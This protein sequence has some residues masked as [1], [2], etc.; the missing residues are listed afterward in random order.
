MSDVRQHG[1]DTASPPRLR[2][3]LGTSLLTIYGLGVII[4]AGIYVLIGTVIGTAGGGAPWSF[5]LAGIPHWLLLLSLSATPPQ[6]PAFV[7]LA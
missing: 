6:I 4:G 5:L 7:F 1:V 3:V 2:R